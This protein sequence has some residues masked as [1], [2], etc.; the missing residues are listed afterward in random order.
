MSI[1]QVPEALAR[2][3]GDEGT[4]GLV[5][6]LES[7]REDWTERVLTAAVDRFEYRLTTELSSLRLDVG[8]E[9]ST[10]REDM[11]RDIAA[12]R[13]DMTQ[14]AATLRQDF[15]RDLTSVRVELLKWSFLFGVG[16]VAAMAGLLAF[17]IRR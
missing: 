8:R 14:E 13:Q 3:L 6:L 10:L 1:V 15:T 11:T 16:Q 17:M 2:R 4:D 5:A 12:L 7:T 9:I